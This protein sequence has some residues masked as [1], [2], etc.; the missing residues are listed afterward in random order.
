MPT[1]ILAAI[2]RRK[3]T[4]ILTITRICT[5]RKQH[6]HRNVAFYGATGGEAS[7]RG[8]AVKGLQ[9]ETQEPTL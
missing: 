3:L 8:K 7:I 1:I 5:R 9:L 2:K 6:H 4:F